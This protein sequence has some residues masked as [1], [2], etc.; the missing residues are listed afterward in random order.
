MYLVIFTYTVDCG[1]SEVRFLFL[2]AKKA[3]LR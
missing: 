1:L 3:V 2:D